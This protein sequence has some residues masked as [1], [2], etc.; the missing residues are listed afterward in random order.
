MLVIQELVPQK[1]EPELPDDRRRKCVRLLGHKILCSLILARWKSRYVGSGCGQ[2]IGLACLP[3]TV[4][5]VQ[6]VRWRQTVVHANSK[7]IEIP[8][9]E[10]RRYE[11]VRP[12][13]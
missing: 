3:E 5:E 1:R 7:L 12:R 10:L 8:S 9:Q 11:P 6:R 4:P 2:R 13:I